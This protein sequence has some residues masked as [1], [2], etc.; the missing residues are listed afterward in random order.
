L[1]VE[2][3]NSDEDIIVVNNVRHTLQSRYHNGNIRFETDLLNSELYKLELN[4]KVYF[5][6]ISKGTGMYKSG[7][8]QELTFISLINII[9]SS[10][11]SFISYSNSILAFDDIDL[12]GELDFRIIE[13][14]KIDEQITSYEMNSYCFDNDSFKYKLNS[15]YSRIHLE[16]DNQG[17]VFIK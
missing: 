3:D 4:S 13:N 17:K 12:D 16:K 15:K 6:L 11:Y 14:R 10:V 8:L 7:T 5:C 2:H 9:N 1:K